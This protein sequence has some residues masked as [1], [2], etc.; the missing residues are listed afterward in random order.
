MLALRAEPRV[1]SGLKFFL[2]LLHRGNLRFFNLHLLLQLQLL[3]QLLHFPPVCHGMHLFFHLFLLV[4]H[5]GRGPEG[6]AGKPGRRCLLF[7]L[8]GGGPSPILLHSPALR[9]PQ[10]HWSS[11]ERGIRCL[12]LSSP[13]MK[14][15]LLSLDWDHTVPTV[16]LSIS[17][18]PQSPSAETGSSQ[19]NCSCYLSGR[20]LTVH[21]L[22][23]ISKR[24]ERQ[25]RRFD[26]FEISFNVDV[27]FFPEQTEAIQFAVHLLRRRTGCLF[28]VGC[29]YE[30]DCALLCQR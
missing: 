21:Q 17:P 24:E 6:V 18:G 7:C 25:W 8:S 29:K 30:G 4:H 9:G 23:V 26:P 27:F 28:P 22:T 20:S 13:N 10:C 14:S 12:A 11:S 3:C 19:L 1:G 16:D 2:F 15:H 5:P